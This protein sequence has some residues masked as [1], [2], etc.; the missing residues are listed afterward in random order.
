MKSFGMKLYIKTCLVMKNYVL[1]LKFDVENEKF[2]FVIDF[3]WQIWAKKTQKLFLCFQTQWKLRNIKKAIVVKNDFSR[4]AFYKINF[5]PILKKLSQKIASFST[6]WIFALKY[7]AWELAGR[8]VYWDCN[9]SR[10]PF[11]IGT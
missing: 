10:L 7:F 8:V 5:W 4:N 1:D 3:S 9:Q 6:F 11:H 2:I